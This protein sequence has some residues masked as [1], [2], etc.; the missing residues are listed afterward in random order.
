MTTT[1]VRWSRTRV[2]VR[3]L[4]IV[5]RLSIRLALAHGVERVPRAAA[6]PSRIGKTPGV[7]FHV[8][9]PRAR[10][11]RRRGDAFPTTRCFTEEPQYDRERG[12]HATA[13]YSTKA[14]FNE[15]IPLS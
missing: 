4:D 2:P 15:L 6:R 14:N 11:P 9:V 10:L 1:A 7:D 8:D 12:A 3:A 5:N 13:N